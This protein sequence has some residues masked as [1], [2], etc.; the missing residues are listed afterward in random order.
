M[1][2]LKKVLAN[3]QTAYGI[4]S[5]LNEPAIIEIMGYAGYDFVVIDLEHSTVDLSTMEHMIRAAEVSNITSIVRTPQEDYGTILRVLEA[6]ADA[7]MVPHLTTKKMA[8]KVIAMAK[9][10]PIGQ[11]GVDASTRVAKFGN[12]NVD[13]PQY[14]QQQNERVLILGMIEDKEGVE[15]IKEIVTVKGLDLLWIGPSDLASSYG[16]PGQVTHPTVRK[17]IQIVINEANHA[18]IKVGIPAFDS[19]Q[20]KESIDMGASLITSPA[21]DSSYLTQVFKA[22][23]KS[24]KI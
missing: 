18:G 20:V 10:R 15:N 12:L 9:Y 22:H 8:E 4:F 24:I 11:R 7:V 13:L 23:L 5:A 2:K 14:M 3:E 17:A 16:L 21:V 1:N 19:N 6:G